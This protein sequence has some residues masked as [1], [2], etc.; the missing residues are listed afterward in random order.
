MVG[1][2]NYFQRKSKSSTFA[3]GL[4]NGMNGNLV[5]RGGGGGRYPMAGKLQEQMQRSRE[6]QTEL[7][8]KGWERRRWG[9]T[10]GPRRMRMGLDRQPS[11]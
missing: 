1:T 7:S 11:M 2:Y 9:V 10:P 4:R 3:V 5:W 6:T 8:R